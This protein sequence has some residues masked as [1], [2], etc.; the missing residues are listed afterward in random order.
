FLRNFSSLS[1]PSS[2]RNHAH[3]P[4]NGP[5]Q[6]ARAPTDQARDSSR[7]GGGAGSMLGWLADAD[8]V[9]PPPGLPRWGRRREGVP[10]LCKSPRST[11]AS[12]VGAAVRDGEPA[13]A[14]RADSRYEPTHLPRRRP[15]PR[16][17]RA[18]P[19]G[20]GAVPAPDAH[21]ARAR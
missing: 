1:P 3:N 16:P 18:E 8:G 17:V 15:G 6:P 4:H 13:F 12:P 19:G 5:A 9:P 21:A 10:F 7:A 2:E 11:G 14:D 20:H